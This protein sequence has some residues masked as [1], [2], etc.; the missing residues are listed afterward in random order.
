M[1]I[2]YYEDSVMIPQWVVDNNTINET[3]PRTILAGEQLGLDTIFN[4]LVNTND[5]TY[6]DGTY[7]VYASFRDP[8]GDVL[9]CDDESLLEAWY[10]FTV[11]VT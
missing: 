10:E 6:G 8:E 2:H 5:L 9:I 4:G 1:Q 11:N 3:T 7:R